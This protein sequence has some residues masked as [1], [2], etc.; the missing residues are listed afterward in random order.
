[1]ANTPVRRRP[2]LA[3]PTVGLS[4]LV[5]L[6]LVGC[7]D[8]NPSTSDV[9]STSAETSTSA[10]AAAAAA[11]GDELCDA[12]LAISTDQGPDVD[13]ET[14]TE[15]EIGA[16]M[17]TY[18]ETFVPKLRTLEEAAPADVAE[19]AKVY[20]GTYE[21]ILETG[22]DSA[23]DDDYLEAE[24]TV[25][26][27]A[28]DGCAVEVLDA[29]AVDYAYQGLPATAPAGRIGLRLDNQ[30]T[31]VHEATIYRRLP[32]A[33]GTA[34]EIMALPEEELQSVLEF[35]GVA[36][37]APSTTGAVLLDLE[38]G[39]Y[40]VACRLPIGTTDVEQMVDGEPHTTM[41]MFADLSV[42]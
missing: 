18:A 34:A 39:E 11:G 16:A 14:A 1:M 10:A 33:S 6:A 40:I 29:V 7:G 3:R 4:F 22:D 13:F 26:D 23:F 21:T 42:G 32:D 17:A 5:A 12:Y 2:S 19:A 24:R 15:D 8:G 38:P 30:G 31:E 41:G 36:F 37:V 9:T 25:V 28:I 27:A 35:S 20:T